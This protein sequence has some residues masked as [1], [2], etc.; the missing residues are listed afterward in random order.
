MSRKKRIIKWSLISLLCLILSLAGFGYWFISLLYPID[1]ALT[2]LESMMPGDLSYVME[3]QPEKRGKIL[4][5]VT[6]SDTMGESQKPTG[7]E[8]SEL[9]RAWYVFVANGFEV[10]VASP[11]GGKAPVV[12]DDEDMGVYDHAFLN[13]STAQAKVS[14]TIAMEDVEPDD[15]MAI[16]FVGGKGAMFDFPQNAPIQSIVRDYYE[17]G[18]VVGAVCHGPAALA[19]VKLSNGN[20][21]LD[22][23]AICGFTNQEE[24][25][26]IKDAA[27]IFPFLLQDKLVANGANFKA[28]QMYLENVVHDGNLITGQNPWS[29]WT[30]AEAMIKQLGYE[31][32]QRRKTGEENTVKVLTTFHKQGYDEA[33]ELI[34]NYRTVKN[35]PVNR[36]LLAVHS[37]LAAM[38]LDVI[39][40]I[41]IIGLLKYAKSLV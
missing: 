35:A 23:K 38:Q 11:Q 22:G 29:T 12:I 34:T 8:M 37:I 16:Y 10:D 36:E 33:K 19:N 30:L 20:H 24:L 32:K 4:A 9:A 39:K 18:K 40:A 14:N 26:L 41:K 21:L 31:P 7:Y 1:T 13:D 25:F 17:K 3:N 27:S 15:Y 28:G 5:V 2:G 6:S